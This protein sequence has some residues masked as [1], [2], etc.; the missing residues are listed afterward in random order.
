MTQN[1]LGAENNKMKHFHRKST[2]KKTKNIILMTRYENES[3]RSS[4]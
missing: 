4:Y 2:S 1:L 3:K